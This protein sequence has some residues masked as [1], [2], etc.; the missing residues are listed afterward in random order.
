LENYIEARLVKLRKE[1]AVKGLDAILVTKRENYIWLSGFSGT[2]ASLVVTASDAILITDFRYDE[3][4]S[5]QAPDYK[6]HIYRGNISDAIREVLSDLRVSKLGFEDKYLT[7]EQYTDFA[8]RFVGC[9]LT[10]I[11]ALIEKLREIKDASEIAAITKAVEIADKAFQYIVGFIKPGMTEAEV[12]AEMEYHMRKQGA[13][14][15]S[16]DTIVASGVRSSMPHGLASEKKISLGD[17][18]TMDFGALYE[19]YCSDM[20][21]TVFVGNPTD[22][23][24][25]IYEIVLEAQTR[26]EEFIKAGVNGRDADAVAR[27]II[28]GYGYGDNFGHGLGHSL[29]LEIHEEPRL[30][31]SGGSILAS[32]MIVTVEPG[33]YIKEMGGVRIEDVVVVGED[34]A[35]IL[36]KSTKELLIL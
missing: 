6:I 15:T 19:N 14:G 12:A 30:S 32:N 29:G 28:K 4:A 1:M 31:L 16:F 21:R 36:T 26:A 24:R 8:D 25:R 17:P 10:P 13:S 9:S 5:K 2:S 33:I 22:E 18:V 27:D 34:G 7:Y 20:T 35:K 11:G 3:Q 23:M